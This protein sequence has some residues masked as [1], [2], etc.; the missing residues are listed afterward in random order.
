[1]NDKN[2]VRFDPDKDERPEGRTDFERLDNQTD[3]EIAAAVA[4]DPDAAPLLEGDWPAHAN[5]IIPVGGKE[6]ITIR[7][8]KE[9]LEF[10]RAQG[11]GYQTRINIVLREFVEFQR[12]AL[13]ASLPGERKGEISVTRG[14]PPSE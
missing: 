8:D 2:T 12:R 1:M 5:I 9:V 11:K 7:V 6:T 13:H 10:F 14:R 3:E 4:K